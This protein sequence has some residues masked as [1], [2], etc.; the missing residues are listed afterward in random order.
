MICAEHEPYVLSHTRT[1]WRW[2]GRQRQ[3]GS[4]RQRSETEATPARR[5]RVRGSLCLSCSAAPLSRARALTVSVPLLSMRLCLSAHIRSRSVR[6]CLLWLKLKEIRA[7]GLPVVST[8]Y[9]LLSTLCPLI[10]CALRDTPGTRSSARARPRAVPG[11]SLALFRRSCSFCSFAPL[12]PLAA[13]FFLPLLPPPSPPSSTL[14]HSP[15]LSF[16]RVAPLSSSNK[17]IFSSSREHPPL[18]SSSVDDSSSHLIH[19]MVAM[20]LHMKKR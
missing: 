19:V 13:F 9:L 17:E 11:G 6:L 10:S 5:G 20:A 3:R 8:C 16:S 1:A 4:H 15:P 18:F 12:S 7:T 14:S 2:G